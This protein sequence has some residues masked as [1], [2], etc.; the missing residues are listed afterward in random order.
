MPKYY[1]YSEFATKN[2]EELHKMDYVNTC[3]CLNFRLR[4]STK[5]LKILSMLN[6]NKP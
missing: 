4:K 5:N 3:K 2:A 6:T 1:S